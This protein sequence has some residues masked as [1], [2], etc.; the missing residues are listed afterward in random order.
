M[1]STSCAAGIVI[2]A[3]LATVLILLQAQGGAGFKSFYEMVVGLCTMAAV[4]PYAFCAL[5]TGLVAAQVAGG[6]PVPRLGL[7]ELV[8]FVFSMFTLYGCGAQP[9]LYGLLLL[10][11]GIPV[12]VWQRRRSTLV[13]PAEAG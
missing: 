7:I 6:G 2:S 4:V 9:V 11:M 8:A 13:R 3:T 5:A 10:L 12:Y 1:A